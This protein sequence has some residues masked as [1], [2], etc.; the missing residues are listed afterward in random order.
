MKW[1]IKKIGCVQSFL[2]LYIVENCK[3]EQFYGFTWWRN[4]QIFDFTG[5]R[6]ICMMWYIK[7]MCCD[8]SF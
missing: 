1:Y 6:N 2:G 8:Q 4:T 7:K 3:I 5:W